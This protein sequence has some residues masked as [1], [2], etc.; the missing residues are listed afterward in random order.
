MTTRQTKA[1]DK[2]RGNQ[3]H[4]SEHV[5]A[6]MHMQQKKDSQT[7]INHAN[8]PYEHHKMQL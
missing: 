6:L 5:C 4:L 1:K 3:I 7:Q 8:T 2:E